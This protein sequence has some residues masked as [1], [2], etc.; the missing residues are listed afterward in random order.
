MALFVLILV[1]IVVAQTWFR[2]GRYK[3]RLVGTRLGQGDCPGRIDRCF[4]GCFKRLCVC[5]DAGG[6]R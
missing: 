4:A 2:L 5:L 1:A 6:G 3:K